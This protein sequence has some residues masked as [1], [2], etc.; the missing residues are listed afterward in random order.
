M[1]QRISYIKRHQVSSGWLGP[2]VA[3]KDARVLGNTLIETASEAPDSQTLLEF[4]NF[5]GT[6]A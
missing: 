4:R 2:D 1:G 3:A 5:G 6:K